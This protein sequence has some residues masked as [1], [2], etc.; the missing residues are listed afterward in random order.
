MVLVEAGCGSAGVAAGR[1]YLQ[2]A[3]RD[4]GLGVYKLCLVVARRVVAQVKLSLETKNDSGLR[5]R[6]HVFGFMEPLGATTD[7]FLGNQ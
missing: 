4:E 7:T 3:L 1:L 6:L 5:S 2:P